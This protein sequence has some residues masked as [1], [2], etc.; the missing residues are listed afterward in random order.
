MILHIV[1]PIFHVYTILLSHRF[2]AEDEFSEI[3]GAI[4]ISTFDHFVRILTF[5]HFE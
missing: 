5:Q 2:N 1:F 3:Q 4:R